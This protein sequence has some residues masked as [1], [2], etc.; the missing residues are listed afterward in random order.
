MVAVMQ[1][2][3]K[4]MNVGAE[5]RA[6]RHAVRWLGFEALA[7]LSA[8]PAKK[9]DPDDLRR[10]ERDV[11]PVVAMPADL[12]LAGDVATAM[13]AGGRVPLHDTIGVRRQQPSTPG[14]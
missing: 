2:E 12:A 4:G 5:W 9:L 3:Q 13:S 6:R 8:A 11:D 10:Q 1:I 7:A 14:T